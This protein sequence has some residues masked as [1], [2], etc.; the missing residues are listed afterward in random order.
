VATTN[1]CTSLTKPGRCFVSSYHGGGKCT[2]GNAD[3]CRDFDHSTC[4]ESDPCCCGLCASG[5]DETA[6]YWSHD[7]SSCETKPTCT[8]DQYWEPTTNVCLPF[9]DHAVDMEC[10]AGQWWKRPDVREHR[11]R[12]HGMPRGPVL[13]ADDEHVHGPASSACGAG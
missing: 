1:T 7:S 11:R 12:R 9:M 5:C 2:G 8:H 4:P 13:G 3:L 10:P 6:E